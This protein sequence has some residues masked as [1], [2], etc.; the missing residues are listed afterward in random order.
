MKNSKHRL[1]VFFWIAAGL[2]LSIGLGAMSATGSYNPA[3]LFNHGT[4]YDFPAAS[5]QTGSRTCAY[6][7]GA[8]NF[9]VLSDVAKKN[10]SKLPLEVWK[11]WKV[12]FDLFERPSAAFS[13]LYLDESKQAIME[14]PVTALNGE[15][16]I[17]VACGTAFR[18][19]RIQIL[20]QAG[21]KFS[22]K[23]AQISTDGFV[24]VTD[25]LQSFLGYLLLYLL[26]SGS[27]YLVKQKGAYA[28]VR[29]LQFIFIRVG[30]A[31]GRR[32]YGRFSGKAKNRL[33]TVLFF[34][35]FLGLIAANALGIYSSSDGF[36]Y[37][38]I[39]ITAI[40]AGIAA[41]MW[42]K[43]L[44]YVS[45]KGETAFF[46]FLFW[47][48]VCVMD[49]L[50]E[51]RFRYTGYVCLFGLPFVFFLWSQWD[52]P[53]RLWRNL[54]H[55]LLAT[56]PVVTLFCVFFRGK[57]IGVLYN[58]VFTDRED[59]ALYSVT[60]LGVFLFVLLE[61]LLHGFQERKA[62]D[63]IC[64]LLLAAGASLC[65]HDL[66]WTWTPMCLLAGGALLALFL[67]RLLARRGSLSL[68]FCKTLF[69]LCLA[70]ACSFAAVLLVHWCVNELPYRLHTDL[71]FQKDI[72]ESY[73]PKKAMK[74]A[75]QT[76]P[77]LYDGVRCIAKAEKSLVWKSYLRE[78]SL[79]GSGPML[80]VG[81]H[82]TM[83]CS[84]WLEL[85]YR[86]G[87]FCIVPYL[88]M[89]LAA[90]LSSVRRRSFGACFLFFG[91]HL[92]SLTQNIE[93]PFL[94]PLWMM[95]YMGIGYLW[96]EKGR[97]CKNI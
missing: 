75:E 43:P 6:D 79:F 74:L 26:I 97:K 60:M 14:Q 77:G 4:V 59:M 84:G 57:R 52:E 86:Y 1:N 25:W 90:V 42:E 9:T 21:M 69:I 83:A 23:S 66:Y 73:V 80:F 45:W 50:V 61:K 96:I 64:V 10:F 24:P 54:I 16:V 92:V 32:A 78:V 71:A 29:L 72:L 46:W 30:N 40:L 51:K 27:Y 22:I 62:A 19:M 49:F 48:S 18:Y 82:K 81:Q 47:G 7:E 3:Q 11:Q 58:G 94:Q 28:P 95:A 56:F 39:F 91:Y 88:G 68:G 93:K 8:G 89:W 15:N 17:P 63:A 34:L 20:N 44:K 37:C 2:I 53:K 55:G 33:R 36:R 70:A 41:L 12:T 31:I 67:W 35:L 5:L 76:Q 87:I 85:A 13:I 38:L 65:V